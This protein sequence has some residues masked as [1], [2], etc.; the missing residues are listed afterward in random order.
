[1]ETTQAELE[2]QVPPSPPAQEP[3]I[4]AR[5][6][7]P[8]S[9]G[10]SRSPERRHGGFGV[11]GVP[12]RDSVVGAA[13]VT[14]DAAKVSGAEEAC[15]SATAAVVATEEGGV[16]T[17][18]GRRAGVGAGVRAGVGVRTGASAGVEG[19]GGGVAAAPTEIDDGVLDALLGLT[20]AD[21][22]VN[23]GYS[24][25]GAAAAVADTGVNVGGGSI[26][27]YSG[28]SKTCAS[29]S[30]S[31]GSPHRSMA[32]RGREGDL[33]SPASAKKNLPISNPQAEPVGGD[34]DPAGAE[35]RRDHVGGGKAGSGS[36]AAGGSGSASDGV[37]VGVCIGGVGGADELEDWL[38][39]ML[40][41]A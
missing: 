39:D 36:A 35:G 10:R 6:T 9:T 13:S 41:D 22:S 37:G 19:R 25:D 7:P 3:L 33:P 26:G 21:L 28:V 8:T 1:M 23:K 5:G 2:G 16:R 32:V 18:G 34:R 40:A 4:A 14:A 24:V 20:G 11:G 12:P 15:R 38:D 30:G 27:G 31:S 17:T 29:N